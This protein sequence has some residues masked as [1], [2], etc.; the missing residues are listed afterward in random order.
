MYVIAS[1][2]IESE[3]DSVSNRNLTAQ[4][5]NWD[6]TYIWKQKKVDWA[7]HKFSSHLNYLMILPTRN[8]KILQI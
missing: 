6:A 1:F 2:I 3:N 4:C 7:L 8:Y 5:L